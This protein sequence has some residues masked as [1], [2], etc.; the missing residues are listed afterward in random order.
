MLLKLPGQLISTYRIIGRYSKFFNLSPKQHNILF[1]ILLLACLIAIFVL[2][3]PARN[4]VPVVWA[5]IGFALHVVL[6]QI[7]FLKLNSILLNKHMDFIKEKK[8]SY[9]DYAFRKS[10]DLFALFSR[11]K[12]IESISGEI[13]DKLSHCLTLFRLALI[14]FFVTAIFGFLIVLT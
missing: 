13:K 5:F 8:I 3:A 6:A 2:P 9:F 12:E 14:A 4:Y 10:I 7:S 1:L 11:R